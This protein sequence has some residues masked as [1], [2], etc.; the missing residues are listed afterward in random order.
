[1]AVIYNNRGKQIAPCIIS[2]AKY[3]LGLTT[4]LPINIKRCSDK[5]WNE[6]VEIIG[7]ANDKTDSEILKDVPKEDIITPK[8]NVA[9]PTL[10]ALTFTEGEPE[11]QELFANLLAAS[12]DI[13]TAPFAHP[14]F[15][16]VIKQMT[17]DE[18]KIMKYISTEKA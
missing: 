4:V 9:G 15:I 18:A 3:A 7:N 11:L 12:M 10:Q 6:S 5:Y 14:S 2:K 13:K 8:P 17:S 1:M 16:E